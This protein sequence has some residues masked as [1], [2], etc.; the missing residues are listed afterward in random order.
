MK[1]VAY[2]RGCW[3]ALV[4]GADWQ[5]YIKPGPNALFESYI[6]LLL[7]IPAY[8]IC[9]LA[10]AAQ[11]A[12]LS[13]QAAQGFPLPAF[14]LGALLYG[15]VFSGGV[16]LITQITR[17][18]AFAP[19]VILRHWSLFFCALLAACVFGLFLIGVLPFGLANLI[20]FAAYFAT[21]LIDI[22]LAK[23]I[24]QLGWTGAVMTG[25]LI[26][27]MELSVLLIGVVQIARI[28]GSA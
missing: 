23:R 18:K 3:G 11:R 21:L 8:Y 5:A 12:A 9:A 20:G 4:G 10:V 27:A 22:M 13:G 6:A 2:F 24:G 1:L 19:W 28:G 15:L 16:Y 25:C 7:T 17:P 26:K 14:V